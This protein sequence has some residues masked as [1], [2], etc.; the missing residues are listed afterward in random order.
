M[1]A[2]VLV[3]DVS[4][5]KQV[6]AMAAAAVDR[7]GGLD[8]AFNNAGID[9]MGDDE[10]DDGIRERNI[11][12]NWSGVMRCMRED[13]AVMVARGRGVAVRFPVL[14]HAKGWR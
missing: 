4:N 5:A 2:T 13:A 9:R 12:I 14:P 1:V 3:C 8:C 11:G 10:Y 7:F 6:K